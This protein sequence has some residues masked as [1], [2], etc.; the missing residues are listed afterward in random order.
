MARQLNIWNSVKKQQQNVMRWLWRVTFY[1]ST[2]TNVNEFTDMGKLEI[3]ATMAI[4]SKIQKNFKNSGRIL[5]LIGILEE[6]LPLKQDGY[7]IPSIS[8]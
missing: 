1:K 2:F 7:E 5:I 4:V 6:V 3:R 8:F